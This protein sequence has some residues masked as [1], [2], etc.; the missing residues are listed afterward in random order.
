MARPLALAFVGLALVGCMPFH[1]YPL[2]VSAGEARATF[3]PIATAASNMGYRFYQHDDRVIV[4]PDA[5]TRID[6]TFDASGNYAMCVMLKDKNPPG[7]ADAAFAAGKAKGDDVWNRAMALRAATSP[8]A[9]ALAPPAPQP[10]VQ[11]NISH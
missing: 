8:G 2:P 1:W 11:I 10:A 3:A 7:G 5:G 6:Y 4:E 9:P